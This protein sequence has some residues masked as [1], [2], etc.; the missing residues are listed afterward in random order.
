M[1]S[2]LH[3]HQTSP[4]RPSFAHAADDSTVTLAAGVEAAPAPADNSAEPRGLTE[5][6]GGRPSHKDAQGAGADVD[7]GDL[8]EN[9]PLDDDDDVVNGSDD[10]GMPPAEGAEASNRGNG[11]ADEV[12]C[13]SDRCLDPGCALPWSVD[14][15]RQ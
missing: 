2:S 7:A 9:E 15:Q 14:I 6:K 4:N 11:D 8:A 5:T 13:Q 3:A 12:C 1:T 10:G